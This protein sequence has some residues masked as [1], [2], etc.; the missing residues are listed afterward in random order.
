M[1]K[2]LIG[3]SPEQW[4]RLPLSEDVRGALEEAH[5]VKSM[6]GVREGLRRQTQRVM[7]MLR[8]DDHEA[9][10]EALKSL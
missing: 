1:A 3:L 8:Q 2:V 5:R 6:T 10:T 4:D 7:T 9:I